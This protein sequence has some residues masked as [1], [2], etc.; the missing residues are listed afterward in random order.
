MID[1][2]LKKPGRDYKNN[3]KNPL[4]IIGLKYPL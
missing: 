2:K 4:F 1:A 3:N